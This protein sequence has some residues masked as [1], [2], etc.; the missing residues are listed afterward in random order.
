MENIIESCSRLQFPKVC[1]ESQRGSSNINTAQQCCRVKQCSRNKKLSVYLSSSFSQDLDF[2]LL[3][4]LI[5]VWKSEICWWKNHKSPQ[6]W[7]FWSG[8]GFILY[9][10][11]LKKK[12]NVSING[13]TF[14]ILMKGT[15]LLSLQNSLWESIKSISSSTTN[16]HD[17][18]LAHHWQ[19]TALPSSPFAKLDKQNLCEVRK[20]IKINLG[21]EK[22]TL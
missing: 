19:G 15:A 16:Q 14:F 10:I 13:R 7:T 8:A 9:F 12:K 2:S 22:K 4:R 1:T 20:Q 11:G 18:V 5:K 6:I 21:G 3:F 17:Y